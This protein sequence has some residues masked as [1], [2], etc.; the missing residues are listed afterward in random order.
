MKSLGASILILQTCL[1]IEDGNEKLGYV[2]HKKCCANFKS[3]F[4]MDIAYFS[5]LDSLRISVLR[6]FECKLAFG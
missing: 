4:A 5:K 3:I 6:N 2:I 1:I